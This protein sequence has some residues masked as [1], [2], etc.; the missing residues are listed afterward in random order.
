[1]L[2]SSIQLAQVLPHSIMVPPTAV[3]RDQVQGMIGQAIPSLNDKG[4]RM[5]S[6][7]SLC[8]M[9]LPPS[10]PILVLFYSITYNTLRYLC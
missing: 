7:S 9:P 2:S 8:K 1:M 6:S 3:T 5:S 10:F 4:K